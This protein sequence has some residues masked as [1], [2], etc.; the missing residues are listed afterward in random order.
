MIWK[1]SRK[2]WWKAVGDKKEQ[3]VMESNGKW[4]EV[5]RDEKEW[6]KAIRD[7]KE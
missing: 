4:W 2:E 7:E 1:R 6:W 3:E 5:M